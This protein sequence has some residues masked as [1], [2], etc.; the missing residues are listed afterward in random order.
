MVFIF[1]MH[2]L[3]GLEC[4]VCENHDDDNNGLWTSLLVSAYALVRACEGG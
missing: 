3:V 2:L 1:P 4:S